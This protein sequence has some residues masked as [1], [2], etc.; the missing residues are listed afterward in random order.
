MSERKIAPVKDNKDKQRTY[1]K[2]KAR[3]SSAVKDGFYLEAMM[4]DYALLE[5]RF[6]SIL[7]HIGFLSNRKS[8][9]VWKT[10]RPYFEGIVRQYK[11]EK[12]NDTLGITNI[13]GKIK[14]VRSILLWV[15]NT[16]GGYKDNKHLTLLK[17]RFEEL[18]IDAFLCSIKEIEDWCSY[19]NEIV[20]ALMNKNLESIE[21]ELESKAEDGMRLANYIDSQERIIKKGNKIRKG[22]NLV[23]E[24]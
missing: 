15:A 20:H 11:T 10:A 2:E 13:S 22:I 14:I 19:R 4:I 21:S 18:D 16:D 5:D 7:Y 17:S 1:A 9:N 24:K 3:Y 8:R 23:V 12:E 6:R